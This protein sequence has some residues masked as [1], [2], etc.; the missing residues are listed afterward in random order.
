M[1]EGAAV[2]PPPCHRRQERAFIADLPG[3]CAGGPVV[4]EVGSRLGEGSIAAAT[5]HWPIGGRWGCCVEV[6]PARPRRHA[7]GC[8]AARGISFACGATSSTPAG[9]IVQP[10]AESAPTAGS[11]SACTGTVRRA[12]PRG[13]LHGPQVRIDHMPRSCPPLLPWPSHA[14]AGGTPSPVAIDTATCC[15]S[16]ASAIVL[17]SPLGPAPTMTTRM[18]S[19]LPSRPGDSYAVGH[20]W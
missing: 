15:P 4:A 2:L 14:G 3:E 18:P 11:R 20:P 19:P 6:R 8:H 17:H 5:P 1:P 7:S 16:R 13:T 10:W 12:A 9:Q